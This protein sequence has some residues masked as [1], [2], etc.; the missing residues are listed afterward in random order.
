ML[1]LPFVPSVPSYRRS[2]IV[3][4]AT[5]HFDLRWNTFDAAWFMDVRDIEEVPVFMGAKIVLGMYIGRR[6]NHPLTREGC[7]VAIDTS[8]G[9]RDAGLDDLGTRVIVVWATQFEIASAM[10][11]MAARGDLA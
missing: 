7:F 5:Y 2:A 8:G 4:G 10:R 1:V 11:A 9:R 6:A 3:N